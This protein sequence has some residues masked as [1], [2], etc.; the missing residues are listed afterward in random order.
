MYDDNFNSYDGDFDSIASVEKALWSSRLIDVEVGTFDGVWCTAS[1]HFHDRTLNC[2]L[3]TPRQ[4]I[5]AKDIV[6]RQIVKVTF[7]EIV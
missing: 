1:F 2:I 3:A 5:D 7:E 4:R 6:R